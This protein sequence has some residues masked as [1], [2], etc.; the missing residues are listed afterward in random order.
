MRKRWAVV[1][2]SIF[3]L[4]SILMACK[5]Q[6]PAE[7]LVVLID[8]DEGPI[9]PVNFNTFIGFWM[10]GWVY[11][12][13]FVRNLDL[14]PVPALAKEATSSV[15]GLTW[16]VQLRD[17]V[18]WHDGEPFTAE[19]VMFSYE[20]LVEAGRAPNL[21]VIDTMEAQGDY[22]LT[23][24]L[25][26]PSPFFISEGLAGYYIMPE[27][28][29]KD[30]EPVSGELNQYQGKI[31][32]GAYKLVEIVPG[33]SYTFEANR[34]YYRGVPL[35]DSIVAK[36]VKDRTQQFNQ[37]R[38]NVA[39]AVLSSV[40]PALVKELEGSD[41]INILEGSDF[42]N[43]VIH[44]NASRGPMSETAFRHA[45]ALSI[46]RQALLDTVLLGR[47]IVLPA[48]YYHPDLPWAI[49]MPQTFDPDAA[50][51]QL[52]LL[53]IVDSNGNGIRE[54]KDEE[55]DLEMLCDVNNVIE[56]RTSE[57]IVEWLN[58]VGIGAH[59]N[60]IDI[61][62]AVSFIWPNF[63]AVPEPD[64]DFAVWGWSSGPQFQRGFLRFLIGN[65]ETIGWANLTGMYD[66]ELDNMENEYVSNPDLARQDIL[67]RSIQERFAEI[68]PFIPLMSPGGNF[69][70]RPEVYNDWAYMKGTG[71]MTVWSF[72][73][74]DAR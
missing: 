19:D 43:Y 25:K 3:I 39:A 45:M 15:D 65:P 23:L 55:L 31:G 34:D 14:E 70:Y 32:T 58:D 69:A 13:L 56:V 66:E 68:L 33:E 20:F 28:I 18:K 16:D 54:W 22:A 27:H 49:N 50:M 11:D 7:P 57:I 53:G 2:V 73:P 51:E 37:L 59:Q 41:E 9:T 5:S 30:Q 47:G 48:S 60:C 74:G 67:S 71:I 10:I 4:S 26:E 42:F 72:L 24:H 40:P 8:N 21:A 6:N 38:S 36:V 52:D 61:D 44:T 12:P 64:Y 17:D 29:W 35:A 46:D 63:V 62:T 1:I